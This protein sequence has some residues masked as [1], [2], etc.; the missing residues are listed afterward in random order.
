MSYVNSSV[1]SNLKHALDENDQVMNGKRANNKI[2]IPHDLQWTI[3]HDLILLNFLSYGTY[4]VF[5]MSF[6]L[7]AVKRRKEEEQ[8]SGEEKDER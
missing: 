1:Q 3:S 4:A 2:W 6:H 7:R 5:I 8:A